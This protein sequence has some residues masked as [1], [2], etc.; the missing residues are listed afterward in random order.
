[1]TNFAILRTSKL[2]SWGNIGGSMSHTYRAAGMAPNADPRLVGRNKTLIGNAADGVQD[3]RN[4]IEKLDGKTR[5]NAVLCV[6][7][8]L[9]ASP[10]FFANK[11][12]KQIDTWVKKN[13]QWLHNQYGKENVRADTISRTYNQSCRF[14][15]LQRGGTERLGEDG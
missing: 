10:E 9:T 4:R 8:L 11:S 13:V 6:E 14:K 12:A 7:H 2:K 15:N 1:M 5:S 3:I